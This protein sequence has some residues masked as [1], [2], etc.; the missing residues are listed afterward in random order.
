VLLAERNNRQVIA[1]MI[2]V[3]FLAVFSIFL[4]GFE[5]ERV[6]MR[7]L[8]RAEMVGIQGA[9]LDVMTKGI[10]I[11]AAVVGI[12]VGVVA[13]TGG[14]AGP[15]APVIAQAAWMFVGSSY[16]NASLAIAGGV[17]S[18]ATVYSGR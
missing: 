5:S 15:A 12:T 6:V 16:V 14:L 13:I 4:P 18:G 10:L 8:T 1:A 11:T 9:G 3:A 7:D 17:A 2:V